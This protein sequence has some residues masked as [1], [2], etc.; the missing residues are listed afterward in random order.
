M[1]RTAQLKSLCAEAVCSGQRGRDTDIV[2]VKGTP[3]AG[4][5][6]SLA[7]AWGV[8]QRRGRAVHTT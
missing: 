4:R 3:F 2:Y 7:R 6:V 5:G 8:G 1:P